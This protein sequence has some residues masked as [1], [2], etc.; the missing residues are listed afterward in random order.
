MARGIQKMFA[1]PWDDNQS[2]TVPRSFSRICYLTK[3]R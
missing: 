1:K 3:S 2:A